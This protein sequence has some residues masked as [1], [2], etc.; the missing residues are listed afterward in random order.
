MKRIRA[1]AAL[2]ELQEKVITLEVNI[3]HINKKMELMPETDNR[4]KDWDMNELHGNALD[5]L[6][7]HEAIGILKKEIKPF[8]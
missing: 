3:F 7:I 6:D 4:R 8:E 1:N 5:L 2:S